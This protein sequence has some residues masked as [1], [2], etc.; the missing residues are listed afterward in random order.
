MAHQCAATRK[1]GGRCSR[2][3]PHEGGLCFMHDPGRQED[4]RAARSKGGHRTQEKLRL[5]SPGNLPGPAP[6]SAADAQLWGAW[7]VRAVAE[8]TIGITTS[9]KIA[10]ALRV[11]LAALDKAEM[12]GQIRELQAQVKELKRG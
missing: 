3:V 2:F 11:F 1:A 10:G 4:A 7:L 12:E 5:A 8:G 6:E 9:D